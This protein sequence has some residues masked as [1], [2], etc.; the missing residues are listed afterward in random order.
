VSKTEG[1]GRELDDLMI[2]LREEIAQRRQGYAPAPLPTIYH[3]MV[4]ETFANAVVQ[5]PQNGVAP[6]ATPWNELQHHLTVAER[7]SQLGQVVPG[8]A[9]FGRVRRGL[10]HVLARIMLFF[11]RFLLNQQTQVNLALLQS[12]RLVTDVARQEQTRGAELTE[13]VILLQQTYDRQLEQ[14]AA[15]LSTD[16]ITVLEAHRAELRRVTD[17]VSRQSKYLEKTLQELHKK[18]QNLTQDFNEALLRVEQAGQE[19]RKQ[20][21]AELIRREH[22]FNEALLRVEQ[23]KQEEHKQLE[24]ALFRVKNDVLLQQRLFAS[25]LE[26]VKSASPA[27]R[28]EASAAQITPVPE[29]NYMEFTNR[30]RGGEESIKQRLH[31]YVELFRGL[32]EVLDIGCGRGEFLELLREAGA[33]VTGVDCD[34]GMV[35]RCQ[36]KGLPVVCDDALAY[37]ESLPDES[38]GGIFAAQ[39]VEHFQSAD[40]TRLVQ[41]AWRKLQAGGVLVIETLN[42]ESL[43]VHYRWFWMDLTHVRLVH[44]ETLKLLFEMAGFQEVENRFVPLPAGPLLIP[45]LASQGFPE[46]TLTRFNTATDYLNKLLHGSWDYA[47]IGRKY[48][49]GMVRSQD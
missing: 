38:L 7:L 49:H 23:A 48:P 28:Q 17:D 34:L 2:R 4:P 9:R 27:A 8:W 16:L 36:E 29:F 45:P 46:E 10:A 33:S 18:T 42:P 43:L 26:R 32:G 25:L 3:Q 30:F 19:E 31:R 20:L 11:S 35:L 5:E 41:V 21:E 6:V 1:L 15:T 14:R 47:V 22:Y 24:R 44:P 39:V 13:G 40:L 12:L 37:L